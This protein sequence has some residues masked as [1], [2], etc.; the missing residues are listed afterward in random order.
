MSIE[1]K[2]CPS[3]K[4]SKSVDY[5]GKNK[6]R[7]DNLQ[8]YCKECYNSK[9]RLEKQK[10]KEKYS[11]SNKIWRET[12]KE[13]LKSRVRYRDVD[14]NGELKRR[15]GISLEEYNNL[16]EEQN[17]LCAI[18]YC[19]VAEN[20]KALFVDHN[21]TTN[22]VRGLLCHKC[23]TFLSLAKENIDILSSAILYIK[24]HNSE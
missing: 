23:N 11:Q 3:C 13:K 4:L 6:N 14:R 16:L 8:V 22:A 20:K 19:S 10:H 1:T 15:Y 17:A 7:S 18:C 9:S 12:N 5:F 2:F 24:K 21:H